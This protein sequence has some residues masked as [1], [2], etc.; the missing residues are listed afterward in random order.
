MRLRPHEMWAAS[1]VADVTGPA[2]VSMGTPLKPATR[3]SSVSS[4][5]CSSSHIFFFCTCR[6]MNT[7][8]QQ[9][10]LM[11][12]LCSQDQTRWFWAILSLARSPLRSPQHLSEYRR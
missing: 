8:H 6:G 9:G 5:G 2:L 4:I 12:N 7:E 11:I 3:L 1:S 10:A